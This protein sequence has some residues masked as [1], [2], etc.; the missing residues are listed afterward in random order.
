[1]LGAVRKV[2]DHSMGL[3]AKKKW[4]GENISFL[5]ITTQNFESDSS[6]IVANTWILQGSGTVS[7]RQIWLDY[8]MHRQV[9]RTFPLR[10][11]LPQLF[12][13]NCWR[14][15]FRQERTWLSPR[16]SPEIII[17]R[18]STTKELLGTS[19]SPRFR[20]LAQRQGQQTKTTPETTSY[21]LQKVL[22]SI[23]TGLMFG[24]QADYIDKFSSCCLTTG[25]KNKR[26]HDRECD[27]ATLSARQ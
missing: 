27:N 21:P 1:M 15:R 25:Y 16:F 17:N 18:K 26:Q 9:E 20:G 10:Q 11:G 24:C 4:S 13:R 6:W 5:P 19:T 12:P 2:W 7:K 23:Q 3:R 14:A 8:S 22:L